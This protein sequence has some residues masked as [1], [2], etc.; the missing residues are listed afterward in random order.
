MRIASA[1]KL[2]T[3]IAAMQCV[4]RGLIGLDDDVVALIPE[5]QAIK[6]LTGY[7]NEDK[8]VL[9]TPKEK[10]RLRLAFHSIQCGL[11]SFEALRS[12]IY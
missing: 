3:S 2:I 9:T 4:E 5:L 7:D 1:S 11:F 8:P 6:I 10:I 12:S